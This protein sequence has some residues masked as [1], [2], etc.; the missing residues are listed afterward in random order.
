MLSICESY[1]RDYHITFNPAKSKLICFNA[2]SSEISPI[3]LNGTPVT[4]VNK[5]KHVGNTISTDIYDRNIIYFI[6][7]IYI[8]FLISEFNR[9]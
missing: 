7:I 8:F 5:D 6:F 3:Y 4:V 1:A 2:S 9:K